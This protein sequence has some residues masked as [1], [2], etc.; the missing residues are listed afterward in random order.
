LVAAR[1]IR[2]IREDMLSSS[3]LMGGVVAEYGAAALAF[4]N[5]TAAEQAL[6][7]LSKHE[8]VLDA[9][10]YDRAGHY[11][12]AYRRDPS[13]PPLAN[14]IGPRQSAGATLDGAR[15]TILRPVEVG[16]ERFGTLVLHTSTEPLTSRVRA[17]EQGLIWLAVGLLAASLML[18]WVLERMISRRLHGLAEVAG[19]IARKG[20]YKVRAADAGGDE[21]GVLADAFNRMLT[22]IERRQD[23]ALRAVRV[24]DEFL[25]VASHELK[26]PLTSLKLQV[27]GLLEM[28]PQIPD[29]KDAERLKSSFALTERQVRRL[30]RLIG[31]LLDV[32]RIAVGRF[33]LQVEDVDLVSIVRDVAAQ[34]SAEIHRARY[35]LDLKLPESARGK[36]DPLRLEQVVVNLL[37]NALKYG[38]G[39]PIELAVEVQNGHARLSV[40][41][42]GIGVEEVHHERIFER[43]ERAVSLNY[44]GL[45]LGLYITKQIVLAHGGSIRVESAPGAG[46]TFVVE[47]PRGSS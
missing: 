25:S 7:A 15:I 1:E 42:Q 40:R 18:A 2:D 32:S 12:A 26:T 31:N 22:E 16:G 21:I 37:S 20:D 28:P 47:I 17:Y 29:G 14:E 13:A 11:Y 24:R 35:T 41:D 3:A 39:K 34:F 43:F 9:A 8:E 5:R 36:W 10:L 38:N 23:E 33:Q 19:N 45:G 6:Q 4:E 27:Q 30:E 46:S 44:G